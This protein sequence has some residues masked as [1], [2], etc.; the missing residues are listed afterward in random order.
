MNSAAHPKSTLT[1]AIATKSLNSGMVAHGPDALLLLIPIPGVRLEDAK[2]GEFEGILMAT[3]EEAEAFFMLYEH[4]W[5]QDRIRNMT[6]PSLLML[7]I[8]RERYNAENRRRQE[9]AEGDSCY[10]HPGSD[11][12]H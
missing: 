10:N 3:T 4:R 8:S 11:K 2:V 12:L 7:L 5:Q 1:K 9:E 6:S